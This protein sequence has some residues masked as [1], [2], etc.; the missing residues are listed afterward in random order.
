MVFMLGSPRGPGPEN[1]WPADRDWIVYTGYDSSCSYIACD[2]EVADRLMT[3]NRLEILPTRLD[4]R[5]DN[6]QDRVNCGP[7]GWRTPPDLPPRGI[8]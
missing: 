3:S 4:A 5:T 6:R 2:D 8:S 7:T 1:F